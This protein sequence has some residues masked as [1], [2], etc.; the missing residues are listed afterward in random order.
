MRYLYGLPAAESKSPGKWGNR[1]AVVCGCIAPVLFPPI[2]I[3]ILY[4]F[5][6]DFSRRVN[7]HFCS[8][9]CWD[10]VFKGT[11]E[12]GV[13][14]YKHLY[15]NATS[16]TFKIWILT[17]VSVIALY[18]CIRHLTVLMLQRQ[19]RFS[20]LV[21]FLSSVFAHYYSWWTYVNYWND[22]YYSQWNHQ[23]FFTVSEL[24]STIL[25]IHLARS[26]NP[27]T[28]RKVLGIIG[29]ALIH[30]LAGGWDQFI[31]NVLRGEGYSHQAV[32]PHRV[33][34]R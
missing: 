14:S 20:M 26:D 18:E 11:Y 10:T 31:A 15:F 22:D 21:L 25:V 28:V 33:V 2:H 7:K 3:G 30:V 4:Y 8:C 16:N 12:T 9:S 17:V 32:E 13:P 29:I 6:D 34:R 23:L 24:C 5:W 27:V 19:L 1:L